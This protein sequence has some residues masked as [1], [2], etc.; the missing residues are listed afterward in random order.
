MR[1][2]KT[3][4]LLSLE[5]PAPIAKEGTNWQL[6][7]A[8]LGEEFWERAERLTRLRRQEQRQMQEYVTLQTG[9]MEFLIQALDGE[10]GTVQPPDLSP[11]PAAVAPDLVQE[12]V[13]F[14]RRTS[15]PIDP[16]KQWPAGGMPRYD[17]RGRISVEHRAEPGKTLSIWG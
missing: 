12:A 6:T 17:V 5:L 16:R 11:L 3:I 8:N 9:H 2:E 15:L 13:E 1:I 4:A 10:P 7:A 14:F